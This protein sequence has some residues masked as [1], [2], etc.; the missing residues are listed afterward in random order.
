LL[1]RE[2]ARRDYQAAARARRLAQQASDEEEDEEEGDDGEK[3]EDEYD[4]EEGE[5]GGQTAEDEDEEVGQSSYKAS[6]SVALAPRSSPR[7]PKSSIQTPTPCTRTQNPTPAPV[8][9][10]LPSTAPQSSI[11]Q[12]TQQSSGP[13]ALKVWLDEREKKFKEGYLFAMG[14]RVTEENEAQVEKAWE[15]WLDK[16]R[17]GKKNFED[18]L[19]G[20][21]LL[22]FDV[23]MGDG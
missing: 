23:E 18:V 9:Q 11:A 15:V 7:E 13:N 4:N 21:G 6:E 14:P 2:Q 19:T 5:E 10:S 8:Q 16:F 1:D 3:D 20:F 12:V 17:E 22:D